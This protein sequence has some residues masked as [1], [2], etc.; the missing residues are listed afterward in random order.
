MGAFLEVQTG[1][2]CRSVRADRIDRR[3]YLGSAIRA[4]SD[5]V[6]RNEKPGISVILALSHRWHSMR[7][8][9][10]FR[11]HPKVRRNHCA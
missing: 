11:T 4:P 5:V 6:G 10:N 8:C 2:W 1:V 9:D 3:C 7:Q